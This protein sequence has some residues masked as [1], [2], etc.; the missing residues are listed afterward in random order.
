MQKSSEYLYS[1]KCDYFI[2]TNSDVDASEFGTNL[3]S[4][5]SVCLM[6]NEAKG[7]KVLLWSILLGVG[8]SSAK[9]FAR[10]LARVDV[11]WQSKRSN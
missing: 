1:C 4:H 6:L 11:K 2:N 10:F 9:T 3:N 8:E 5:K 7:E